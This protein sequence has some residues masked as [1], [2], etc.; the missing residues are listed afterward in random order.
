L[1]VG[2]MKFLANFMVDTVNEVVNICVG[3]VNGYVVADRFRYDPGCRI[4]F[5]Q[6]F[7]GIENVFDII[8]KRANP[9]RIIF[10]KYFWYF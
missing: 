8:V 2:Q 9:V 3:A 4:F 10:I 1:L 5:I 7:Q 6:I